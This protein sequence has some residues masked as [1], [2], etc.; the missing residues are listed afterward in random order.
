MPI[1]PAPGSQAA[2]RASAVTPEPALLHAAERLAAVYLQLR[3]G[4]PLRV[5][6]DVDPAKPLSA[7]VA[8]ALSAAVRTG[9][10]PGSEVYSGYSQPGSALVKDYRGA[11]Q[12]V[13][14]RLERAAADAAIAAM[15]RQVGELTG[16]GQLLARED[17]RLRMYQLA[18][19]IGAVIGGFQP[20]AADEEYATL[21]TGEVT[22]PAHDDARYQRF[23]ARYQ[24]AVAQEIGA[25]DH[26]EAQGLREAR[27]VYKVLALEGDLRPLFADYA[28]PAPTGEREAQKR[29]AAAIAASR[30]FSGT[31]RAHPGHALRYAPL[32][33]LGVAGLGL[34]EVNGFPEFALEMAQVR[35]KD[36]VGTAV[37]ALGCVLLVIGVLL[38][39]LELPWFGVLIA[40]TVAGT[41]VDVA[42]LG[43]S[44][45]DFGTAM[46]QASRAYMDAS[47]QDLL[48]I[49]GTF[50]AKKLAERASYGEA[51][52]AGAA[53][54]LAGITLVFRGLKLFKGALPAK[55][56]PP[57]PQTPPPQ[58]ARATAGKGTT[59]NGL[60][61]RARLREPGPKK[62]PTPRRD[63]PP[64]WPAGEARAVSS[65]Q[66]AQPTADAVAQSRPVAQPLAGTSGGPAV[67]VASASGGPPSGGR[68]PRGGGPPPG[69]GAA[70]RAAATPGGGTSAD[71]SVKTGERGTAAGSKS[72]G[73]RATTAPAVPMTTGKVPFEVLETPA[74]PAEV[75][76][77]AELIRRP[78]VA[79]FV[80][81]GRLAGVLDENMVEVLR[82]V[83]AQFAGV[84]RSQLLRKLAPGGQLQTDL[85]KNAAVFRVRLGADGP[86]R[87]LAGV[88]TPMQ[89]LQ[90]VGFHT[91]ARLIH[92]L[93]PGWVVEA[94][95]SERAPCFWCREVLDLAGLTETP[96]FYLVPETLSGEERAR[97]LAELWGLSQ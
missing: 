92:A 95:L 94:I 90:G 91:E 9:A 68:P 38:L 20:S 34:G 85:L 66:V 63:E 4:G 31:I 70:P 45:A 50:Q 7:R 96:I 89:L 29:V 27:N 77:P 54:L 24:R 83:R 41:A 60:P 10:Y 64:P 1:G 44:A 58:A 43:L 25:T 19:R 21:S 74:R 35:N 13:W 55:P 15:D 28:D 67:P 39:G 5:L 49:S 6:E 16:F 65:G 82:Y 59:N 80:R 78:K 62:A 72:T 79:P 71:G 87:Y 88:N 56:P 2:E 8:Q 81:G 33:S 46:F 14:P 51:A 30:E 22:G 3:Q 17:V 84:E 40:P 32:V 11:F 69:L 26:P 52:L 76:D 61:Q 48:A 93:E 42:L 57:S 75:V 23:Y 18:N 37:Y 47:E 86:V 53:A 12:L 97:R 73:S 36:F